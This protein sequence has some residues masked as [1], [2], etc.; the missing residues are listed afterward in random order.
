MN[1]SRQ[2]F[3]RDSGHSL[4]IGFVQSNRIFICTVSKAFTGS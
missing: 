2:P 1:E 3:R 4:G